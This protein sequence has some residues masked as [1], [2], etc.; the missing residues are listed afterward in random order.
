MVISAGNVSIF[1][2]TTYW[3]LHGLYVI[4]TACFLCEQT[5]ILWSSSLDDWCHDR[6]HPDGTHN[7]EQER[8]KNKKNHPL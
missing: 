5:I 8:K 2:D 1:E 4:N 7:I 3:Y 6:Q